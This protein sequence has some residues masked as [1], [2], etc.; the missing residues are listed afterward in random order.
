VTR[1]AH[2]H[3]RGAGPH[4]TTDVL[5]LL[6]AVGMLLIVVV[7]V[8][9][10]P[11]PTGDLFVALAGGRDVVAG[12]IAVP[13]DWSLET[14][15]RVWVNQNW[16]S[17]L[18]FYAVH[19]A[20]GESGLVVLKVILVL[21]VAAGMALVGRQS[22]AGWPAALLASAVGLWVA[23]LFPELR[24]N[25]L[26]L[27]LTPLVVVLLRGSALRPWKTWAAAA[28]TVLW[29]N[30]HGGF[31]L[32]LVAMAAWAVARA[33][34]AALRSGVKAVPARSVWSAAAAVAAVLGAGLLSP[35]GFG[36]LT[37]SF[38]LLDPGWRAVREWQPLSLATSDLFGSPWEF[39]AVAVVAAAGLLVRTGRALGERGD[40][41]EA[42]EG[43][44]ATSAFDVLV[45]AGAVAM[46]VSAWRFVGVAVV[47]LA[48]LLALP[49]DTILRS[50]NRV[51]RTAV[52][53]VALLA[54]MVP[55]LRE[56]AAHY[57]PVN[58]RFESAAVF[59]RMF[60]TDEF[61][62]QAARFLVDNHVSGRVFNEWRW[63]GYLRWR[64][65]TL[66]VF[67]GGRAQQVYDLSTVRAYLELPA[68]PYPAGSLASRGAEL[69]VV[70]VQ[71]GFDAMVGR[72]AFPPD[73]R[74]G[75]VF[76]DGKDLVLACK[77]TPQGSALVSG[78]LAGTNRF[79]DPA[80][81]QLSHDLALASAWLRVGEAAVTAIVAANSARPTAFGYSVSQH[82]VVRGVATQARLASYLESEWA[83]LAKL[84]HRTPDGILLLDAKRRVGAML[85]EAYRAD[86]RIIEAERVLAA[87]AVLDAEADALRRW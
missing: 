48:P 18:L 4:P 12:R 7:V 40:R 73:A 44:I 22:G 86:A 81:A 65:P 76:F 1:T 50:R 52:A 20:T 56:L 37:F 80:I 79:E 57:R 71:M 82:L 55:F 19:D 15:G 75:V 30:I 51:A 32:G 45:G 16:G 35:F 78:A 17:G 33:L 8:S 2:P 24:P 11:V 58:L 27:V 66:K 87:V 23:R 70:P 61:P 39:L 29:A 31:M 74:W 64:C 3:H 49:L 5:P 63:E 72:L 6:F 77:D 46:A 47:V 14:A 28:L 9:A 85:A 59:D 54:L 13:D 60:C 25:L 68:N 53:S 34:A 21:A 84:D 38:R 83:R 43:R 36:N 69:V 26:T 67:V 41:D 62:F 10:V 42:W